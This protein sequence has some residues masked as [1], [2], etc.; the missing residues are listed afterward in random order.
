MEPLAQFTKKAFTKIIDLKQQI[1][2]DLTGKYL[3]TFDRG[4]KY[5]FVLYEYYSNSILVHPMKSWIDR[6]FLRV[7]KYLH[8]HLLAN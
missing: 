3:V 1:A 2:T 6:Y 5:I 8:K 4:N 7:F